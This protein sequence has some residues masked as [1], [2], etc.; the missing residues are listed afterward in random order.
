LPK[1]L[2]HSE[3]HISPIE[4]NQRFSALP[5]VALQ[6]LA[7]QVEISIFVEGAATHPEDDLTLATAVS[8]AADILVTGD[9]QLRKLGSFQ[10][11][12]ILSPAEFIRLLDQH[13]ELRLGD[14]RPTT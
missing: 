7:M 4:Y 13:S 6:D 10:G 11:V 2:A 3:S 9:R 5:T 14:E 1:W 8:A 12:T